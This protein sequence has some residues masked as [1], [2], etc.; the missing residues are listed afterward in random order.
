[1]VGKENERGRG[2]LTE[3]DRRYLRGEMEYS[4][5]VERNRRRDIRERVENAVKDFSI[6]ADSLEARDREQVFSKDTKRL[7]DGIGG[8]LYFLYLGSI[9]M[10]MDFA[11]AV[12]DSVERAE[13]DYHLRNSGVSVDVEAEFDVEVTE[14]RSI[15]GLVDK[16]LSEEPLTFGELSALY[17]ASAERDEDITEITRVVLKEDG[18]FSSFSEKEIRDRLLDELLES[19]HD[20][21]EA[22]DFVRE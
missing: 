22:V 19:W 9:D 10:R 2:F 1:M 20:F 18:F 15:G 16:L 5:Q 7:S 3:T 4:P 8:A 12:E 6:V 17:T 13:Y 14:S 21:P 11:L